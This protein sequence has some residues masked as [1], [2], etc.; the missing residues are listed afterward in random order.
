MTE[1]N[2]SVRNS[3]ADLPNW[4]RRLRQPRDPKSGLLK[5]RRCGHWGRGHQPHY[6]PGIR[7]DGVPHTRGH[8]AAVDDNLITVDFDDGDVRRFNNYE[9]ARLLEI[10]GG[11]GGVVRSPDGY[12]W[13][14]RSISGFLFSIIPEIEG[15]DSC[16]PA[17][18]TST[19]SKTCLPK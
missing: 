12:S 2:R 15:W 8:L 6:I 3:R 17:L 5:P 19:A 16:D 14:L 11:I 7:S 10:V 18:A 4:A 9:P 1:Q 13:L